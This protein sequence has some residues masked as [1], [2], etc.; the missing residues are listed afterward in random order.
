LPAAPDYFLKGEALYHH[1]SGFFIGPTFDVV[2]KRWGDFANTYKI[3]SYS[4][5]G[6]RTGWSDDH[7]KVFLEGRNLLDTAYVASHNVMDR[8]TTTDPMLNAGAPLSFY[9]GIEISY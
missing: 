3:D 1:V 8:A 6:M 9:G 5:L 7:Y 2:G 4:L